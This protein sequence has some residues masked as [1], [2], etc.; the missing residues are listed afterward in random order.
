MVAFGDVPTVLDPHTGNRNVGWSVLSSFYDPLVSLS[1]DLK[2]EPALATRWDQVDSTHW[3]FTLRSGV[4]FHDGHKLTADDVVA[5]LDRARMH[6]S[7]AVSGYL[8]GVVSVRSDGRGGQSSSRPM[9]A[10]RP[11]STGSRS[12]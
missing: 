5:S 2:P 3:R 10:S 8:A 11:F 9:A 6:R 7:S 1:A 4:L 12:S